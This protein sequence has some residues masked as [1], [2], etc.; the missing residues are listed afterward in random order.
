[1]G[2]VLIYQAKLLLQG[3]WHLGGRGAG[4][5]EVHLDGV[6][7]E[8]LQGGQGTDHDDTGHQTLPHTCTR[9]THTQVRLHPGDK[10]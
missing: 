2:S 4:Q 10:L 5:A 1:M 8:P 9:H 3:L 6:I 7:D